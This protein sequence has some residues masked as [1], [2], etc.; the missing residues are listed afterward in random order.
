M[1]HST[2]GL[3]IILF[4]QFTGKYLPNLW[5]FCVLIHILAVSYVKFEIKNS[6]TAS[7]AVIIVI[8]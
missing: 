4:S 3:L 8:W 2:L 7:V 1:D 5:V 6:S